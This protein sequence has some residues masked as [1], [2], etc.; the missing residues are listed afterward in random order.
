M[1]LN[2]FIDN[3]KRRSVKLCI[4]KGMYDNPIAFYGTMGEFTTSIIRS[5]I[6]SIEIEAIKPGYNEFKI[7]L[8]YEVK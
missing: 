4:C 8:A 7:Y 6:V 2:A 5:E 3:L 1:T